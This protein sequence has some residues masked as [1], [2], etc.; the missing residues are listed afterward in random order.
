MLSVLSTATKSTSDGNATWKD[1][2]DKVKEV[3]EKLW[4]AGNRQPALFLISAEL[5]HTDVITRLLHDHQTLETRFSTMMRE[6]GDED[7]HYHH[8]LDVNSRALDGWTALHYAANEG[9]L[10]I[11]EVLLEAKANPTLATSMGRTPLHIACLRNFIDIVRVL[12]QH[13]VH[14]TN[15]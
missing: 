13:P 14:T 3:N 6:S 1:F 7:P 5:G 15:H 11:V 8:L 2:W 12:V 4:D 9:H 10:G